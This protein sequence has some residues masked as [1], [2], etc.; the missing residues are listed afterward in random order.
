MQALQAGFIPQQI[1]KNPKKERCSMKKTVLLLIALMLIVPLTGC[2]HPA[3][4]RPG[5]GKRGSVKV[6]P[7]WVKGHYDS[8]G[9]WIPGHWR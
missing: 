4:G 6:T 3:A 7:L 9:R 1:L 5:I 2:R 8:K